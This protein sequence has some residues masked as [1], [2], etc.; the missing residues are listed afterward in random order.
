MPSYTCIQEIAANIIDQQRRVQAKNTQMNTI[1]EVIDD[2]DGWIAEKPDA[3]VEL[4]RPSSIERKIDLC[5]LECSQQEEQ[6]VDRETT[7]SMVICS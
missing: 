5:S 7:R 3:S 4:S 1:H 2:I 6:R